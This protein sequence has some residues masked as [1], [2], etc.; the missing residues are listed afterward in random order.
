MTI[1]TPF[2]YPGSKNKLLPVLMEHIDSTMV[3]QDS[4]TD[5][6]VGG[7]SVLLEVAQ[8]YPNIKLYANDK[9]Y[10]VY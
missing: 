4:F 9:N 6:F 7:G 2:R 1:I 8:K 3:G 10:W 5:V